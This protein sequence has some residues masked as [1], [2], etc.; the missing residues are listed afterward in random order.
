MGLLPSI[1]QEWKEAQRG[2]LTCLHSHCCD[3]TQR[4][5]SESEFILLPAL[6]PIPVLCTQLIARS[7]PLDSDSR[8]T[9]TPSSLSRN[10]LV[11][12]G[13]LWRREVVRIRS[14]LLA[15][16]LFLWSS[17]FPFHPEIEHR[18]NK[19]DMISQNFKTPQAVKNGKLLPIFF[20]RHGMRTS[21]QRTCKILGGIVQ[22]S[23]AYYLFHS[24]WEN[25]IPSNLNAL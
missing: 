13:F 7:I 19:E 3:D 12:T 21:I 2:H 22:C 20:W 24:F 25:S 10:L 8:T 17:G 16:D 15:L 18:D 11:G 5:R 9:I 4:F 23:Y 1:H 14:L 6:L